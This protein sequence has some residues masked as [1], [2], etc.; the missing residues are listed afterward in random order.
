MKSIQDYISIYRDIADN[1]EITG[2]SVEVLVQLLAQWS[3]LNENELVNYVN[4]SSLE[5]AQLT[6]SKIQHC[7]DSVYS[8]FI[9]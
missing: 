3:Y 7:V 2:D 5:T 6:N 4:E 9:E 1:L 8:V